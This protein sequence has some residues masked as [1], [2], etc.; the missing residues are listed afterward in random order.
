MAYLFVLNVCS[1][2]MFV[3]NGTVSSMILITLAS[4][5]IRINVFEKKCSRKI[6][7]RPRTI[8]GSSHQLFKL[9]LPTNWLYNFVIWPRYSTQ[10]FREDYN[11]ARNGSR[12]KK[13]GN[14]KTEK[15]ERHHIYVWNDVSSKKNG[16]GQASISYRHL[17]QR[18]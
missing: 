16:R 14:A 18:L 12:K 13:Q 15:G 7:R 8:D 17:G 10:W 2:A 3:S 4:D 1:F 11:N 5:I 9:R 6:L